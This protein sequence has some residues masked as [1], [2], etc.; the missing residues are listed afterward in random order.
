MPDDTEQT[1]QAPQPDDE[2]PDPRPRP[3]GESMQE[4]PVSGPAA[5]AAGPEDF[6]EPEEVSEGRFDD[7][8][9]TPQQRKRINEVTDMLGGE[10]HVT[11][12]VAD[13]AWSEAF[14]EF[15]LD[16][17]PRVQEVMNAQGGKAE[18][19][20][21]RELNA[22]GDEYYL[23]KS[24]AP[25]NFRT[26]WTAM[27]NPQL[28]ESDYSRLETQVLQEVLV[29]PTYEEIDWERTGDG[30]YSPKGLTKNR[31]INVFWE[32]ETQRQA[33]TDTAFS[34][35]EVDDAVEVAEDT[36]EKKP[37]L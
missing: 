11:E 8:D 12:L 27:L 25:E 4:E 20:L 23:M 19:Y 14:A 10:E 9:L 16:A 6:D 5:Q 22:Q 33:P 7:M 26:Q 3:G 13:A 31:L 35:D 30:I 17:Y 1:N 34:S 15:L 18:F 37:S 21:H 24:P 32:Y 36:V 2:V 29:H 28:E